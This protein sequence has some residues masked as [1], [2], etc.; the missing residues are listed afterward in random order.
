MIG[1]EHR[2]N[3]PVAIGWQSGRQAPFWAARVDVYTSNLL[4]KINKVAEGMG[5]E[6]TIRD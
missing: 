6:P 2:Q 5:F 4:S 3:R 1:R